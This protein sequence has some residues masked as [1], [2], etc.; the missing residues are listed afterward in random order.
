MAVPTGEY[1]LTASVDLTPLFG[2]I[3]KKTTVSV[4][5]PGKNVLDEQLKKLD[6]GEPNARVRA[7]YDLRYFPKE[8]ARIVPVLVKILKGEDASLR[9]AAISVLGAFP[10]EMAEHLDLVISIIAGDGS[11]SERS[12]AAYLLARV[13]PK[14]E[15]CEK[16]LLDAASSS[17]GT[18]KP[19][20]DGAL[21]N[22]RRR[23][24]IPKTE[25]D[26]GQ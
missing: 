6:G 26:S 15:R 21:N 20:F 23:H 4:T 8:G 18:M 11:E 13:A 14:D 16:A 17:E 5:R 10:A 7:L 12:N 3:E 9:G 2:V 22:Y 24:K 19:R 25:G 1:D